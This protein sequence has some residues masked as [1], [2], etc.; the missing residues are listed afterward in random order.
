MF[1]IFQIF[2]HNDFICLFA[3]QNANLENESVLFISFLTFLKKACILNIT[4]G[5]I[6]QGYLVS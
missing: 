3:S 2:Y 6:F 4:N 1:L 5:K